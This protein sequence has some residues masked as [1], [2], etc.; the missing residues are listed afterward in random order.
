[1]NDVYTSGLRNHRSRTGVDTEGPTEVG[2]NLKDRDPERAFDTRVEEPCVS[3]LS[4]P[5]LTNGSGAALSVHDLKIPSRLLAL[6]RPDPTYPVRPGPD[7]PRRLLEG[8]ARSETDLIRIY[9]PRPDP[10]NTT[11][12][13]L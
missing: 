12:S 9:P 11:E 7:R 8:S 1:M 2:Y 3:T 5:R 6:T 10:P 13:Q 4:S